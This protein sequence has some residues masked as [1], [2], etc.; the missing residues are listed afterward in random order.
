M[1]HHIHE[2]KGCAPAPLANYLK[3][4][5]ILRLVGE[6]ADPQARGWWDG[7]R[8]Y[9]LT[10][11]SKGEVED[12]FLE[13]YEPTPLL[14]PWNKGCGFFKA[15]DPGLSPLE[16]SQAVR[17]GKFRESVRGVRSQLDAIAKADAI[18]RS[19]KA[20][21]KSGKNFQSEQQR[22]LLQS[23]RNYLAQHEQ[24]QAKLARSSPS[25]SDF[26]EIESDLS[27]L[28]SLVSSTK[29]SPTKSESD[30]LKRSSAYKRLLAAAEREFKAC[31]SS[32]V[33]ECQRS[34]RG[35]AAEWLSAAVVLDENGTPDWPS[36]LGTGGND[37]NLDFTNNFM[38]QLGVVFDVTTPLGSPR[39]F[40]RELLEHSL[41]MRISNKLS[42]A[43]IGQYQPGSAGGANSSTG[44]KS[45]CL[46]NPWDF[47]LMMEGSILLSSRASRRLDLLGLSRA[48]APF[49]IRAHAAGF[50]SAGDEGAQRGE[51]WMPLWQQPASLADVASMFGEARIH[52]GRRPSH[53]PIEAAQAISRLGVA[54]GIDSFVRYGYLER[55]GQATLAIPLGRLSVLSHSRTHLT[56]NLMA[57]MDRLHRR[58]RDKNMVTR[59]VQAERRLVESVMGTL[60]HPDAPARWQAV[61]LRAVEIE[62]LQACG[63]GVEAGPI[64]PLHPDWILAT[65]DG[66]PEVRLAMAIGSAAARYTAD[67]KPIDSIRNHWIPLKN[68]GFGEFKIDTKSLR[69]DP[70]IVISGRDPIKD[71][72]AIVERRLI[73]SEQRG[74]RR[75]RL[76]AAQGAEARLADLALFLDCRI[77][78]ERLWGLARGYM[79]V[80]W[81]H[82]KKNQVQWDSSRGMLPMEG[83]LAV[84]LSSLPWRLSPDK[85]IHVDPRISRM[86][87][88]GLS[89]RAIELACTKL[90]AVGLRPSLR[91]GVCDLA[92]ARRW[93]A[94]LAFPISW[95]SAVE[96]ASILDPTFKK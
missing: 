80:N 29:R 54:R 43:A 1:T 37:G 55:N 86:L 60:R 89:S 44:F 34:W 40:T 17:F 11:L 76:V 69:N 82:W 42:P 67:Q 22:K 31:K 35:P 94:A 71:L 21:T 23:S 84:R 51:Q 2:L 73:E 24:L 56:D 32:L 74:E 25:D 30:Y 57:W 70:R 65:N 75:S 90:C 63:A 26:A 36:I 92:S 6:Q 10:E 45:G 3:A 14:S 91:T 59:F 53:R 20:R 87:S 13:S 33:P 46:V 38:Q 39:P 81:S 27:D 85:D 47:I 50:A 49:A 12:F 15:N 93:A 64:P 88:S 61:L 95:K 18:I 66:S 9:L 83:W 7:D 68:A 41:W 77:D 79:A 28:Q 72:I 5:G 96:A 19:I 78:L 48:S 4:L 58:S 52:L 8:F 16:N 62:T